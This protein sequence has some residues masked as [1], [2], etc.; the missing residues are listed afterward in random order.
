M[1]ELDGH[2]VPTQ[3][4]REAQGLLRNKDLLITYSEVF[5]DKKTRHDASKELRDGAQA[6]FW[7]SMDPYDET[8]D[9]KPDDPVRTH[10]VEVIRG[11]SVTSGMDTGVDG[12]KLKARELEH[13]LSEPRTTRPAS[14]SSS[15]SEVSDKG[16]LCKTAKI[17]AY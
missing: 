1:K 13:Q 2:D 9:S 7:V 10:A 14:I 8:T 6:I 5:H 4:L 3:R 12:K 11:N 16:V 15:T 17:G